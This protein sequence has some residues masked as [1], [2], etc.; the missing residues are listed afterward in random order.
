MVDAAGRRYDLKTIGHP[1][2]A[3]A[4][5]T[6][7]VRGALL[8]AGTGP[9]SVPAGVSIVSFAFQGAHAP[10]LDEGGDVLARYG[11]RGTFIRVA[12][13]PADVQ[14]AA[15]RGHEVV[16]RVRSTIPLLTGINRGAID[17]SSLRADPL[18]GS[19]E[20]YRAAV[21]RL[22]DAKQGGWAIFH[23][24]DVSDSPS[25]YGAR[26]LVFEYIVRMAVDAGLPVMTIG[27]ACET[28]MRR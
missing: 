6:D 2:S 26:K 8:P 15:A 16:D 21:A 17:A 25:P 24:R 1:L 18:F 14:A 10:A 19:D 11:A 3:P 4:I 12:D 5:S 20:T 9:F 28:L 13:L 27:A 23:M 22:H 7:Y